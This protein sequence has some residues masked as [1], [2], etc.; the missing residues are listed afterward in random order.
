MAFFDLSLSEIF[1]EV[2]GFAERL[3]FGNQSQQEIGI[4]EAVRRSE[5]RQIADT[6][7]QA[8]AP[9]FGSVSPAVLLGGAGLL[10]ALLLLRK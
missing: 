10:V 7:P 8:S 9:V 6:A 5:Q 1:D 3:T 2:T 4:A